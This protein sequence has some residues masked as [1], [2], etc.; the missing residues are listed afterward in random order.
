[1]CLYK[2][3]SFPFCD[4][5]GRYQKLEMHVYPSKRVHVICLCISYVLDAIYICFIYSNNRHII[6]N[7]L[8]AVTICW[9]S[10]SSYCCLM[11]THQFFS[12][13][14]SLTRPGI[15]PMIYSTRSLHHQSCYQYLKAASCWN[16][17]QYIQSKTFEKF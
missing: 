10:G 13:F 11:T 12:F 17:W 9:A 14:Y 16:V 4:W 3:R 5:G 1:M 7:M 2:S 6:F 15:E 8:T